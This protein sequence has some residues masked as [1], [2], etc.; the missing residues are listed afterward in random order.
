MRA[1]SDRLWPVGKKALN[2]ETKA[3][4]Y[5]QVEHFGEQSAGEDSI[6]SRAVVHKQYLCIGPSPL[7]V[8]QNGVEGHGDDVV[9]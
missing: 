6:K 7:Q 4:F 2:P 3:E 1:H 9:C 5:V 8:A